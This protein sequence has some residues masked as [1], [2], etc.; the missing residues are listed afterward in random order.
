M[1]MTW[2]ATAIASG[3]EARGVELGKQV[4][5]QNLERFQAEMA[6][7]L[8][9]FFRQIYL[10]F[11]GFVRPDSKSE[12]SL[13]PLARVLESRSMSFEVNRGRYFAI[14][15]LLIDSDFLMFCL[16]KEASPVVLLHEKRELAPTASAFFQ[17]LVSGRF[18]FL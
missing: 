9:G 10:K 18:D 2:D 11:N 17:R 3:L 7:S 6:L 12:I 14:G 15:D 16:E 13:W 1:M 4:T 8:D 5:D